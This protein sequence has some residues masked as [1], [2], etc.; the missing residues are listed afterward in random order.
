M[1]LD[2]NISPILPACGNALRRSNVEAGY[3]ERTRGKRE[4]RGKRKIK[5]KIERER[6]R[7]R[8]KKYV[9]EPV[10]VHTGF[11][12]KRYFIKSTDKATI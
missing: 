8:E 4:K 10:E 7:E 9:K 2:F 1:R 3:R 6:E 5:T 12:R 11:E